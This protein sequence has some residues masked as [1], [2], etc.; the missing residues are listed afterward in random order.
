[1]S[2]GLTDLLQAGLECVG[3]HGVVGQDAEEAVVEKS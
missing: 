2:V 1:M 3:H